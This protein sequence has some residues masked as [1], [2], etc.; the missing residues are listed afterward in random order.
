MM[1]KFA[2]C[3]VVAVGCGGGDSRPSVNSTQ[4]NVC[5]EVAKVACFNMY[6]CCSEGEIEKTLG[7]SDPRTEDECKADVERL[8]TPSLAQ[9][10]F[11]LKNNRVRFDAKAM[12]A[13]LSAIEAPDGTCATL[14]AILPW[15]AAC[16]NSA[17]TGITA[18]GATCNFTYECGTDSTCAAG[19]CTPK[20]ASGQPCGTGC[21]SGLFCNN[22][23]KCASQV[24]AGQTCTS[25]PQCMKGLFCDFS[26]TSPTCTAPRDN[27]QPCIGNA[28][29]ISNKCTPG[30][31]ANTNFTCSTSAQCNGTCSNNSAFFCF[32]DEQCGIGTCSVGGTQCFSPGSCG[33]G[34]TCVFPNRCI[35]NACL[36]GV[37]VDNELTVDYCQGALSALPVPL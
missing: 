2:V 27:G 1:R 12:N 5:G 14:S 17:W 21:A 4:D 34:G 18:D 26:A 8:C 9:R 20:P 6:S 23:G 13:C 33:T 16:M 32:T 3:L 29:C 10:N 25:D 31:C 30:M 22:V 24:G 19:V 37:C 15:T 11:S 36:G 35:S 7:V 28:S